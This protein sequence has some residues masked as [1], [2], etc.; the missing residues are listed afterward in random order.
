M[1]GT[2][3]VDVNMMTERKAALLALML[4]ATGMASAAVTWQHVTGT[5]TIAL[6]NATDSTAA[7]PNIS[8]ADGFNLC[9]DDGT[10]IKLTKKADGVSLYR[11]FSAVIATNGATPTVT[12]DVTALQGAPL[13][14]HN[15][16]HF[17]NGATL[18]IKGTNVVE[19]GANENWSTYFPT[20]NVPGKVV[21]Q[22]AAGEEI[23][24]KVRFVDRVSVYPLPNELTWE[25]G[26]GATVAPRNN[27][28]GLGDSITLSN[29]DLMLA[30]T[31][32]T[33]GGYSVPQNATITVPTGRILYFFPTKINGNFRWDRPGG[34]VY[35]NVVLAGGKLGLGIAGASSRLEGSI[36]GHGDILGTWTPSAWNR[37]VVAYLYGPV[38]FTGAV[39]FAVQSGTYYGSSAKTKDS[40]VIFGLVRPGTRITSLAMG[41]VSADERV[42][43][44]EFRRDS[45]F[46]DADFA[47]N[48]VTIDSI[49]T[50]SSSSYRDYVRSNLPLTIGSVTGTMDVQGSAPVSLQTMGVSQVIRHRDQLIA[51]AGTTTM[52]GS[53]GNTFTYGSGFAD[54]VNENLVNSDPVTGRVFSIK[55]TVK[56]A[57]GNPKW[58]LH[59]PEGSQL[60][61]VPTAN[62]MAVAVE[63]GTVRL[64]GANW[65][66]WATMWLDASVASSITNLTVHFDPSYAGYGKDNNSRLAPGTVYY[67]NGFPFVTGWYDRRPGAAI[68]LWSDRYDQLWENQHNI[69]PGTHPIRV[70][71]GLNGRDYISFCANAGTKKPISHTR[72]D[73]QPFTFSADGACNENSRA[74]FYPVDS[75]NWGTRPSTSFPKFRYVFMVLGSQNGGGANLVGTGG[76]VFKRSSA[77]LSA[78]LT[79]HAAAIESG[80]GWVDGVRVALNQ[81]NVLNGGWQVVTLDVGWTGNQSDGLGASGGA[82]YAELIFINREL[83][84]RQREEIE[85]Y[86]AEKWGLA[87]QYH[88]P[89][90]TQKN[91]GTVATLYGTGTVQVDVDQTRLSGAFAGTIDLNGKSVTIEGALPPDDSVVDTTDCTGW[92]D[93]ER[94]DLM[95]EGVLSGRNPSMRITRLY[96]RCGKED[97]RFCLAERTR[98]PWRNASARRFGPVRNW[99]DYSNFDPVASTVNNGNLFQFRPMRNGDGVSGMWTNHCR[100]IILAQDS[101][102]GGGQPFVDGNSVLPSRDQKYAKRVGKK[103]HDPIYPAGSDGL[104]TKGRTYLDGREVDGTTHGFLGR[105]EILSVIPTNTFGFLCFD[106]LENSERLTTNNC[107]SAIHGEI[108]MWDRVLDDAERRRVEAYLSWKWLGIV[109]EGYSALTNATV[110]GAGQVRAETL[111]VLPKFAADCSATVEVAQ[112][113]LVFTSLNGVI[114]DGRDLGGA[115]LSLPSACTVTVQGEALEPGVYPLLAGGAGIDATVFTLASTKVGSRVYSLRQTATSLDLQVLPSG[116]LLIVR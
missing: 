23:D 105:P 1:R 83:T 29:Y 104:L 110:T 48:P 111:A 89:A 16:F 84:D 92:F 4:A 28:L 13:R 34:K 87:D 60:E 50:C 35:N 58:E 116:T 95:T 90:W 67:T 6:N 55:G 20:F 24:G 74:Y 102:Y 40:Q 54:V 64:R 79:A 96:D 76:G 115:T 68:K 42:T 32:T 99:M 22:N 33:G 37:D 39:N 59:V 26:D 80:C 9:C 38:C 75:E 44:F 103:A 98:A 70:I 27:A 49:T 65:Q 8:A 36:T 86:L 109:N 30:E 21:F 19:F 43:G 100:T 72:Y 85:I 47:A 63:G 12:L 113:A 94:T 73:G 66:D 81:Q 107:T 41:E 106:H 71:G 69:M 62:R 57:A 45:S 51:P 10:T 91:A 114:T 3:E 15:H 101:K 108:L 46:S 52:P 7:N 78:G 14:L 77:T 93:P 112:S 97:G 56:A 31:D 25:I 88:Y 82:N 2:K 18:V 17:K 61:L 11:F 53:N 5:K